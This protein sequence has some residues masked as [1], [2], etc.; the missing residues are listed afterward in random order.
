MF[1]DQVSAALWPCVQQIAVLASG[2]TNQGCVDAVMKQAEQPEQRSISDANQYKA[3][4]LQPPK[5]R[6]TWV[7]STRFRKPSQ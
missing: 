3:L 5:P 6:C 2:C 1:A 4:G 7:R